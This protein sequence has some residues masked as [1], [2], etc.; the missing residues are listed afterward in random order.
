MLQRVDQFDYREEANAFA[1]MFD[2]LDTKGCR[3][4]RLSST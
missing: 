2:G 3:N 4:M 1:M